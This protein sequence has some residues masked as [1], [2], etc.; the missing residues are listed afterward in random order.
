MRTPR[1]ATVAW[2]VIATVVLVYA[3][4]A[5]E[6]TARLF[7]GGPELWDHTFS[8]AVGSDHALGAG[9][10]HHE[11]QGVYSAHRWVLLMHTSLGSIA[12]ALA[13][14]QLTNRSRRRPGVH[15]IVGRVQA[16]LAVTAMLGAMTYLVLVGPRGTYDG[17][18]FY[19]QLWG[20]AIGTLAGTVLGVLAARQRHIASHRVLMTYAFALLCTAPFLR[21]L[22]ILLG[23]AWPG[24]TQEVTNLAGGAIEAVWAPMAAILATRLMPVPRS[25][26]VH[27]AITS[28]L[29]PGALA[30]GVL[31]LASL[32]IGYAVSFDG[33]DRVTLSA[34]VANALGLA[35][36]T[37]NLRA[38]GD[39]VARE[40]WRIHH[41][42][43]LMGAPA[44]AILWL[45]YRLP[46][47]TGEAF[48]GA[49][50]TGPALTLSLGLVTVAW[51][52]RRPARVAASAVTV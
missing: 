3:P 34:I 30:A 52:R 4:M 11:Q 25:R 29:E 45:L 8:A 26:D 14:F 7:G 48:Y 33:L 13:V 36:T 41:A 35:L 6:Y 23:M 17:P 49:L 2:F 10:I 9:S 39:P 28:K 12:I 31:G 19:L 20:L 40:D 44:T 5:F 15:R 32:V 46:F 1:L 50:L 51:R 42:A 43:M 16:T 22:Y 24:V 37:V 18:A 21:V 47:T 38:A 27:A